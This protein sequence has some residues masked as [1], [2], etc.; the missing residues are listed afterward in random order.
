MST[1]KRVRLPRPP[2]KLP[3]TYEEDEE[4]DV[5]APK[6]VRETAPPQPPELNT[7]FD[8][9]S[10]SLAD[11]N[12]ALLRR[13]FFLTEDKSKFA[14]VGFYP[15]RQYQPLVEFGGA[16]RSPLLLD[17]QQLQTMANNISALCAAL[18]KNE[19]FI[20]KDGDFRMNTTGSYRVARIYLGK[21]YM[22]F[23]GNELQYLSYIMYMIQNQMTFYT[24][25]MTDVI[26]YIDKSYSSITYIEPASTANK[27]INY[28]Q[29]FEEVKAVL[30]I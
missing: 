15:A 16:K 7:Y 27:S 18:N 4:E 25:A 26:N 21:R 24:A 12:R 17:N 20:K 10:T 19:H 3:I 2:L 11:P 6:R 28:Y 5:D 22:T 30:L 9:A 13:V 8:I 1:G 14:S 23:S 29:L